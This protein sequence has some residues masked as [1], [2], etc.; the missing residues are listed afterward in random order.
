MQ[1]KFP[2]KATIGFA[3]AIFAIL[4]LPVQAHAQLTRGA[5]AGTVR[6]QA[7]AVIPGAQVKVINPQ[8]NVSREVTTNDEGFYRIV[9][10][11]PGIYTVTVE[12][13]GFSKLEN[14]AVTVRQNQ[15]TTLDVELGAGS[16]TGTVDVTAAQEAISLNKTNPTIGLTATARQVVELPLGAARD[17]NQLALLS[18]NVFTAPG[19][20]GI[21]A[22]GQRARN[23]N[24]TIDGSDNNDLSVT[25]STVDVVPEGVG[26]FQIQTNPYNVEAG[27]NSGAQINVITRSGTNLFHGD[28]FNYYRGSALNALDNIEKSVGLTKPTRFVRNQYGFTFGGPLHLPR[29]GEGGRAIIDGRDRTF[30]FYL[31]QGDRQRPGA[32]L[33]GNVRIPTPAGFAA[34]QSVPLGP[35]QS[36]AGR[37]AVLDRLSFLNTVYASGVQFRS[38]NNQIVNGVNIQT[39]LTNVGIS[40]P[41]NYYTHTLRIDHRIG[42]NDN[43]T[44]RYISNKTTD[45]NVI[46]NTAFGSIFSGDQ[47]IFDQNLALSETH[48]FNSRVVNEFRFSYVRRNLGFPENDPGSPTATITGLFTIGGLANFPQGRIQDSFQFSNTVSWQAGAHAIKFGA[49]IRK[50]KLFNIAA[51]DSKGTFGFANL[52]SYINNRAT[53]FSQALNTASFDARQLQQFYFVQDDWRATPNLTL[54]LGLRYETANAPFGFFGATDAQSLA[55]LVPGPTRRDNNNFAPAFGFAYSPHPETGL[56]KAIFGDGLSSIRGGYRIAYDVLFYNILTV[57]ASNFPRVVVGQITAPATQDL[58]PNVAPVTGAPVFNPLATW[59]NTPE[60]AVNPY[61]QLF[62]FSWQREFALDYVLE[63]GYT[64]SRSKNQINQLQANPGI[65]T[66]A[67]AATV[68]ATQNPDSIPSLQARRLFPQFGSRVLIATDSHASYNAG[69]I[70]LNKRFSDNLQFGVAYTFSRLISDNDES[71]GVGAITG[72]SP[73]I[74]QDFFNVQAEKGLSAF[75]RKHRLVANFIYEV[76]TFNASF[77]REG[78]GRQIFGGWQLSGIVSRQSGQPFTMLTGVDT[79]GNGGGGDRPNFNPNGT[80]VLDPVTGDFR[81]FTSPLVG[82]Q[83]IVPLGT[84]GLPLVNG[85]GN[86]NLGK[87]TFRAPGFYNTDLSVRKVFNVVSGENPHRLI[88]RAD[89]L[90]AFNQDSYGRPVNSLNSPDFGRNLNNWGNRTITLSLKYSF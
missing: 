43:L 40:Q 41:A 35:G 82:G 85:L 53:T 71:L 7:G 21:S 38:I 6:D 25:I 23:N 80:L 81:T 47:N 83:F 84:N 59:V 24:F 32:T 57:N 55:A 1:D 3:I 15:E 46:S 19:S 8:T 67:Q 13:T 12:K 9:A 78:I 5:V 65:L 48:I 31:F 70:N 52:Q 14:R 87:N 20:T 89:F 77:F 29:F 62:S 10:I 69:F 50:L 64:G 2:I 4:A 54:N 27:R 51:F 34:L 58:Y 26:E 16:I 33:G 76:P 86:G 44:G 30:F 88:F 39:G 75:D 56:L 22:N 45:V 37:A 49:D 11:E 73:Q 28:V 74:P 79:N 42:D 90:N 60:N 66:A 18:P 17:V 61:S 72:G 63:V 68:R 36:A